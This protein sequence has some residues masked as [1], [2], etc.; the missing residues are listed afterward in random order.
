MSAIS[1]LAAAVLGALVAILALAGLYGSAQRKRGGS[2]AET[3]ARERAAALAREAARTYSR[4]RSPSDREW[5]DD[6]KASKD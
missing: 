6:E 4:E 5:I 1:V 3:R 2:E